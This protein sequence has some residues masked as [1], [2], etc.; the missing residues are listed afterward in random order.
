MV[1][2]IKGADNNTDGVG[3]DDGDVNDDREGEE[4]DDSEEAR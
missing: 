1:T 2:I 4:E 3:A